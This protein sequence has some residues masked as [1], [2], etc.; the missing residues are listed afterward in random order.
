MFILIVTE[1]F[2]VVVIIFG[3]LAAALYLEGANSN[4]VR[5]RKWVMMILLFIYISD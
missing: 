5:A 1:H 2:Y 4:I 3:G